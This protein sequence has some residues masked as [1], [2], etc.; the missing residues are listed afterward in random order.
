[1]MIDV[2]EHVDNYID[3][4][5]DTKESARYKI[6][7]IPLDLSLYA[8][9]FN[10]PMKERAG[11]G[12]LHYW[13]K[14]TALATIEYCGLKVLDYAY[15]PAAIEVN[16]R[17]LPTKVLNLFRRFFSLFNKDIAVRIWGG[18]SLMVIAE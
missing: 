5:K 1:M 12:H 8:L 16:N 14:D 11:V 4:I 2:F 6:F 13:Y 15:T 10:K 18:Y 17:R 3:F 7:H 9:L